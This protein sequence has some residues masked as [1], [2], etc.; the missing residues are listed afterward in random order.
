MAARPLPSAQAYTPVSSHCRYISR[1]LLCSEGEVGWSQARLRRTR[2]VRRQNGS[3]GNGENERRSGGRRL[4]S[5]AP[6]V[7]VAAVP[8][9]ALLHGFRGGRVADRASFS[10]CTS[11]CYFICSFLSALSIFSGQAWTEQRKAAIARQ[12][13]VWRSNVATQQRDADSGQETDR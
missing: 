10:L 6:G 4:R 13:L 9:H 8:P 2:G 7:R 11:F 5:W 3:S 12:L 1:Y